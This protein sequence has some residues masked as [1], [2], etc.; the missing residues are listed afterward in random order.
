MTVRP[1]DD[2]DLGSW[3]REL[4]MRRP[5]PAQGI[6]SSGTSS[7]WWGQAWIAALA[8]LGTGVS[9]WSAGASY[10]RQGRVVDVE[11]RVGG[12]T[13]GVVGS[14]SQA[15]QV[16]ILVSPLST[17]RWK[18]LVNELR[19]RSGHLADLLAG[20][21]PSDLRDQT[22]HDLVAGP[23]GFLVVQCDCRGHPRP[24][25]HAVALHLVVAEALDRD[26]SLLFLMRG[27]ER[28]DLQKQL[29]IET[30]S[31]RTIDRR[32]SKA[33]DAVGH[34]AGAASNALAAGAPSPT[35][36]GAAAALL[37]LQFRLAGAAS[38][39]LAAGAGPAIDPSRPG[40][41]TALL[42]LLG[43]PPAGTDH[44]SW[45]AA[46]LTL[47]ETARERAL[48]WT[49][50]DLG[51]GRIDRVGSSRTDASQHSPSRAERLALELGVDPEGV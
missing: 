14:L 41:A 48:Q 1:F 50:T 18:T 36:N 6:P 13:A 2:W 29:G 37:E 28:V 19:S 9:E 51:A 11:V 43:D 20:R 44:A 33:T 34:P 17:D 35:D 32:R 31:T 38:N 22:R 4:R 7:T 15:H 45:R 10:A 8:T 21:I 46:L 25:R 5:A 26:P 30:E 16:E 40:E 47:Y 49:V 23:P 27:M 39:A 3:R 24:C 42:D 12:A